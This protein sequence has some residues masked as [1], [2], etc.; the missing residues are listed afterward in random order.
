[1][2]TEVAI[3]HYEYPATVREAVEDKLQG[4]AKYFDRIISVRAFLER[5]NEVHRAELV[6]NVGRGVVLVVDAR[7]GTIGEA[8]DEAVDRMARAL[9]KHKEK[10]VLGN[11]RKSRAKP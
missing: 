6:A 7:S 11:R 10:L 8:L 4:L 2:N 9:A 3:L 1:M 5:Q